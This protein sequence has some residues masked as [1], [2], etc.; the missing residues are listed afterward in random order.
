[1]ASRSS[2]IFHAILF[3]S[4]LSLAWCMFRFRAV[5]NPTGGTVTQGAATFSSTG[6]Q[7]NINQSTA[8]AFIN[9]QS[10]NINAGQGVTFNQPSAS[11]VTWNFISDPSASM[12]NGALNANGIVVLQN[13]NGFIVGGSATINVHGLVMTTAASSAINFSSDGPWSFAA[14]PPTA[15]I[16]NYGQINISGGGSAFLIASDIENNGTISAPGGNIGLYAGENV[17]VST[18][19]NGLGLSAQVTLPQ[20]SVDN[21]GKLIADSGS[22]AALAQTV[23]QNGLVQANSAQN[24]NGTI[25]LVA[26]DAV[27]LG[28]N[29][30]ISAHGNAQG[31]SAG[32]SVTIKG[33]NSFSDQAG[34]SINIAGGSQGGNGGQVEISAPVMQGGNSSIIGNAASG[35][36]GGILTIDPT[37]LQ[38]TSS[39]LSMFS[40]LSQINIQTSGNLELSADWILPDESSAASLNLSAGNNI[41]F[42]A[43]DGIQAGQNWGISLIAGTSLPA[44]TTAT[45]GNDE[46]LLNNN[47]FIQAAGGN[48]SLSASGFIATQS[49]S[50]ISANGNSVLMTSPSVTLAGTVQ[51]NS[52]GAINGAVAIDASSSLN[53]E[54]GSDILANGD[55]AATTASPGGFVVLHAPKLGSAGYTDSSASQISVLGTDGGQNGI[56]EIINHNHVVSSTI[57]STYALLEN[58]TT[59]TLSTAALSTLPSSTD[60]LNVNGLLAYSDI[61]LYSI[62]ISSLLALPDSTTPATLA[63][64][65]MNDITVDNGAGIQAGQNWNLALNAGTSLLAGTTAASGNDEILLN[66]N[67]SLQSANG[68]INLSASGNITTPNTSTIS[69]NGGSISMMA[70]TVDE[71]ATL[72]ASSPGTISISAGNLYLSGPTITSGENVNFTASDDIEITSASDSNDNPLYLAL[73]DS[74]TPLTMYLTAGND[75]TVDNGAGIQAGQNWTLNL[76]AGTAIPSSLKTGASGTGNYGIYLNSGSGF[77]QAENGDID[78][79]AQG[80]ILLGTGGIRTI[81]VYDPVSESISINGGNINATSEYGSI[82]TGT[83]INGFNYHWN[84][85]GTTA[86]PY[87]TPFAL[88]NVGD[89]NESIDFSQSQLSGIATAA[90]G[91]VTINAPNGNVTSYPTE[92]VPVNPNQNDEPDPG[93]GAFGSQAGNVTITAGG[94]VY[95]NFILINGV[96]IINALGG[97]IGTSSASVAL[98]LAGGGWTL[99]AGQDIYLQEVRNPNGTFNDTKPGSRG[100]IDSGYHLYDYS[101]KAYVNLMAG[102]GVYFADTSLPRIDGEDGNGIY[103]PMI[104]PPIVNISAGTGGVTL[105]TPETEDVADQTIPFQLKDTDIILFPSPSGNL[106]I[107]TSDNGSLIDG[108]AGSDVSLRMSDSDQTSWFLAQTA[109]QI[110]PFSVE[111]NGNTPPELGNS[112]PVTLS[113][114]GNMNNII[115]QV[116]KLANITVDGNM[117]NCTFYGENLQPGDV[118]SINVVGQINYVSAFT[119]ITLTDPLNVLPADAVATGTLINWN[120]ALTYALNPAALANLSASLLPAQLQ[121]LLYGPGSP[122]LEF[123]SLVDNLGYDSSTL[124]LTAN[125]PLAASLVADLE[126]TMT[127]PLY[128]PNGLPEQY[129]SG[130]II[131]GKNVSGQLETQTFT[132]VP[133]ADEGQL[134]TLIQN[135][136]G[137]PTTVNRGLILGGTG[138]FNVSAASISLGTTYGILSL[139]NG[140]VGTANYTTLGPTMVQEDAS[141]ASISVQA[142]YLEMPSSTIAALGGGSV[143]VDCSSVMPDSGGVSM[144]LG[145]QALAPLENQIMALSGYA[146]GIYTTGG[147]DIKVTGYG[148]INV[149]SSRIATLNGGDITVKSKTGDVDAGSGGTINVPIYVFSPYFSIAN[150]SYFK[151]LSAPYYYVEN[152]VVGGIDTETLINSNPGQLAGAAT[153]PGSITIDTPEGDIDAD[154]GGIIQESLTAIPL[155]GVPTITLMAGT[156]AGGD[157]TSK[158]PPVYLGNINLGNSGAIGGSIVAEATGN[159]NGLL[160]SQQNADVVAQQSFSGTILSGGNANVSAGTSVSGVIVGG[161]GVNVSGSGTVSATLLGQNVSVNGGTSQSTLGSSATATATSQAAA[162]QSTQSAAQQVASNDNGDDDEKKKKKKATI[163]VGRVTVLLS[164]AVPPR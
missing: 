33:G 76:D 103:T 144:D 101:Q 152:P 88:N 154:V 2:R 112:D 48:V 18:S 36:T 17:L 131:N 141:G 129:P 44:G 91:N 50:M 41:T 15:K 1:M 116:D 42:D 82:D 107:N 94:N 84:G 69:A 119:P 5:A 31:V 43:G 39:Y 23:N 117:D 123:G 38:L 150:S 78:L 12:I 71:G 4:T 113:I 52:I 161:S 126:Q 32:G 34:S 158:L 72:Q 153:Q 53:L 85:N 125:G 92:D 26:G 22:I 80:D 134:S 98:S 100:S 86:N 64:T 89:A 115:L 151:T 8:S 156:P 21:T 77:I 37:T 40:G 108:N 61:Y 60:N 49:G 70:P 14:A 142:G 96:G 146:L 79:Q 133:T 30:S 67:A 24:V 139:G 110:E 57:S 75:I 130:T 135:S 164:S 87:Y 122:Y 120:T 149:D 118:T 104:L 45:S 111:D 7:L 63:L 58:P 28:A 143:S 97:S 157:W 106:T 74:A 19:P 51:A 6:S 29:S 121:G 136:A 46:I 127:F 159:I 10:F 54:A 147:G 66:G 128:G 47:S 137:T 99:N 73:A 62:E 163:H 145:S 102:D 9:W 155:S 3:W 55:P 27:N 25:E 13:P 90:G 83:G 114:N 68:N 162:Q 160:I 65:A 20:G 95:G 132:L 16:V 140:F 138:Q 59:L 56:V 11:A 148:T 93:T 35:F 124:A 109:G 81:G 105:E